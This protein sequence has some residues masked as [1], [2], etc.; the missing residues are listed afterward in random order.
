MARTK[1]N[2]APSAAT[3]DKPVR[4]SRPGMKARRAVRVL[5]R[6]KVTCFQQAPFHRF[7]RD[8]LSDPGTR[9]TKRG[10]ALLQ[11]GTEQLLI[12][13]L[14]QC[15]VAQDLCGDI[16]LSARHIIAVRDIVQPLD[17]ELTSRLRQELYDER[18]LATKAEHAAKKRAATKKRKAAESS[19]EHASLEAEGH[20]G[21]GMVDEEDEKEMLTQAEMA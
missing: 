5:C 2:K 18:D 16:G 20:E 13:F 1:K 3:E 21:L 4:R 19:A 10:L 9:F 17:E 8:L 11:K 6:S 14:Q 7:V 12:S 15:R